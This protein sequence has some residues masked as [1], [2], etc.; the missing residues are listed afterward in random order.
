MLLNGKRNA[1]RHSLPLNF[2]VQKRSSNYW[3]GEAHIPAAYLPAKVTKMNAFAIHGSGAER[4]YEA[5]YPVPAANVTQQ[6]KPD[7]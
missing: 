2:T 7:L 4:V 1:I 5:L 3:E 6:T